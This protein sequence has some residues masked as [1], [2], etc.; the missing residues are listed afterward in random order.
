MKMKKTKFFCFKNDEFCLLFVSLSTLLSHP[1]RLPASSLI[2]VQMKTDI[3]LKMMRHGTARAYVIFPFSSFLSRPSPSALTIAPSF[4]ESINTHPHAHTPLSLGLEAGFNV[5][6]N[7][8]ISSQLQTALELWAQEG[9]GGEGGREKCYERGE[10]W[11]E[12]RERT[13]SSKLFKTQ[14]VFNHF[15]GRKY[16]LI[17]DYKL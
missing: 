10:I 1:L 3:N 15:R 13:L 4:R 16:V 11:E 14:K 6:G 12:T 17:W 5:N 2:S 9:G 8:P 7:Q